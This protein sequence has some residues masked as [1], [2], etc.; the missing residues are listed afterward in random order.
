MA[1]EY[2]RK[3]LVLDAR[4]RDA[5]DAG[6]RMRQGY[7]ATN[8]RASVRV[9]IEGEVAKLN[10]KSAT[11]GAAR[12][13]FEYDLPLDDADALLE[14]LCARPFVEKTRYLVEHQGHVWEVDVFEGDNSGLI[15][16]EIELAH[17]QETFARP[18]WVGEEVTEDL[19][20]Y[21]VSLVT[22]PF[23]AWSRG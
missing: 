7:L 16:A 1:H 17:P 19:R 22:H 13:E 4:W 20:Y 5:A 12:L 3:F 11:L 9:R 18:D 10:I 23:S 8:D 21:N 15:V 14:L 6:T 2:E